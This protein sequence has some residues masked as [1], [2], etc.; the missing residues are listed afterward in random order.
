MDL[1]NKLEKL[2]L[3]WAKNV[4][5]L[6]AVARQWL[7]LNVWWIVLVFAILSGI[8][9]LV[10]LSSF[11]TYIS[12]IGAASS[13][14]YINASYT[15]IAVLNSTV[16]LVFLAATTALFGFA[17]QPLKERQ[18]KGWVLLFFSVLVQALSVV[19]GAILSFS[20]GAFIIQILFGAIGIA[21]AAYFVTEIHSEF[22][23]PAKKTAKVEK[24][25]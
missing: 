10:A 17:V 14:Y 7:G 12:L 19:V 23:H 8:A 16:N 11:F 15:S 4:P 13:A 9:F 22:A 18:K 1:I 2:V 3:G 21:I 25:V 24:K 20:V 5:H 6:P